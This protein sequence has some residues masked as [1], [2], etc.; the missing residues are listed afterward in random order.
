MLARSVHPFVPPTVPPTPFSPH[1]STSKTERKRHFWAPFFM[2]LHIT[3][4]GSFNTRLKAPV[5]SM[6]CHHCHPQTAPFIPVLHSMAT[7]TPPLPC[8]HTIN[9]PLHPAGGRCKPVVARSALFPV[10]FTTQ[11]KRATRLP[12]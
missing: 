6:K 3:F 11:T 8:A 4:N 2:R 7:C 12:F 1:F 9:A 5:R 10:P